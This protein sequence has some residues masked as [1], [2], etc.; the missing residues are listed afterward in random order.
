MCSSLFFNRLIS[1]S[2]VHFLLTI[3][4]GLIW[5]TSFILMKWS[6]ESYGMLSI[7]GWRCAFGAAALGVAWYLDRRNRQPFRDWRGLAV[8]IF[9]SYAWP[10]SMQIHVVDR[11]NSGFTAM[12]ISL[13]PIFTLIVSVPMLKVWP[14][15]RQA[16]GVVFGLGFMTLMFWDKFQQ[17]P[18]VVDLLLAATVPL[19]YAIGNTWNKKRFTGV[20]SVPLACLAMAGTAVLLL[21]VSLATESIELN[22]SFGKATLA[23]IALAVFGTGISIAL[24]YKIIRDR[25]PVYA[26]M[27]LYLVPCG[28]VVIGWWLGGETV[29]LWQIIALVGILA[30]VAVTQLELPAK[31]GK[32]AQ[33]PLSPDLPAAC[34]NSE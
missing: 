31:A 8:L 1:D 24:F 18:N 25:G 9:F 3:V 2:T 32:H 7:A 12:M 23:L 4:V 26:G 14:T 34:D 13:A 30:T 21:P 5:S 11:L 19:T 10:Y 6:A 17:H 33:N 15:R 20:R 16:L 27:V 29:T 22:A 28:G